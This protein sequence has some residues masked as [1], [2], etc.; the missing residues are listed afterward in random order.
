M[1][2]PKKQAKARGK[3]ATAV[4]RPRVDVFERFG[5][6]SLS[7]SQLQKFSQ[8]PGLWFATARAKVWEDAGPAAW[9][10]E[11]V[12]AALYAYLMGRPKEAIEFAL[13]STF[14]KRAE[15]YLK[16]TAGEVTDEH[17][18]ALDKA[19]GEARR[20]LP[21][22]IAAV[23]ALK[24]PA[25]IAYNLGCEAH[26][27][28]IPVA[29]Y[30]KPD[31]CFILEHAIEIPAAEDGGA[32]L[33]IPAGE[34]VSLDLKTTGQIPSAIKPDHGISTSLYALARGER[35]AL[36]LYVSTSATE[37][38]KTPHRLHGLDETAMRRFVMA[39]TDTAHRL[40]DMLATALI[41]ARYRKRDP[42]DVLA[43]LCRPNLLAKGGGTFDLWKHEYAERARGAVAAW[44]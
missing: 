10:G 24:L 9:R 19:H 16:T 6:K 4:R 26:L 29:V 5:I 21:R 38:P 15:E 36:T 41:V 39:A 43:Q 27:P 1:A 11:A 33:V 7:P 40:K 17:Q 34:R 13:D 8:D 25:P 32:P 37:R 35:F 23:E 14:D 22:A 42:E 18:E 30:G 3:K 12:E 44:R 2:K 20:C 31:F 28:G